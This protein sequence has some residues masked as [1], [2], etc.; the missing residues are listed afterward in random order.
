MEYHDLEKMNFLFSDVNARLLFECEW[1]DHD[2]NWFD[3]QI[4]RL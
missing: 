2:F 3:F 1:H 4:H